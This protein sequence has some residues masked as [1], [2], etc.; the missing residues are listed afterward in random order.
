MRRRLHT[1]SAQWFRVR[2]REVAHP[3]GIRRPN[4]GAPATPGPPGGA[5]GAEAV[6]RGSGAAPWSGAE[7]KLAGRGSNSPLA[8][9]G[10]AGA[11]G[12]GTAA[13]G[14]PVKAELDGSTTRAAA[15]E[16]CCNLRQRVEHLVGH[17]R[18]SAGD[19]TPGVTP[20][21]PA[22]PQA[23]SPLLENRPGQESAHL[24]SWYCPTSTSSSRAIASSVSTAAEQ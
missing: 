6:E 13:Y 5:T 12:L 2:H 9:P 18:K 10:T 14:F 23:R 15:T 19:R 11:V 22:I 8:R 1:P 20:R 4:G 3:L 16:G 17:A 21:F 24:Y 7:T